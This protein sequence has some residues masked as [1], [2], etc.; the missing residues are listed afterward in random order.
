MG[1]LHNMTISYK[2]KMNKYILG[3]LLPKNQPFESQVKQRVIY[4]HLNLQC[5]FVNI[6]NIMLRKH[7]NQNIMFVP[8]TESISIPCLATKRYF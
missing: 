3:S 2:F 6:N 1:H 5:S 8:K 4:T 7:F